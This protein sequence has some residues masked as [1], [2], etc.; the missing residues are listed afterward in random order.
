[1]RTS[2]KEKAKREKQKITK[3]YR[4]LAGPLR[5]QVSELLWIS[6]IQR[7]NDST[8]QGPSC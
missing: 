8:I 7:F 1:M 3:G 4:E 6:A 2:K 5:I